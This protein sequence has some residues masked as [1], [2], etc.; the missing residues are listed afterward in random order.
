MGCLC[1][2]FDGRVSGLGSCIAWRFGD[3]ILVQCD[4]LYMTG[5]YVEADDL[6]GD[7]EMVRA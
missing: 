6:W 3:V 5:V 1:R 7:G 2:G 4:A